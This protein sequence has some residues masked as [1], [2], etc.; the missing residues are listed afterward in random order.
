MILKR[1]IRK[2]TT[3]Q[4]NDNIV[5]KRQGISKNKQQLKKTMNQTQKENN[6]T[7]CYAVHIPL[8]RQ[9]ETGDEKGSK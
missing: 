5:H 6:L 1:Q 8:L 2:G 4:G 3:T 7:S 9:V